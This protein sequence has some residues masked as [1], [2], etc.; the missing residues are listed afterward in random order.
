[1]RD[2]IERNPT[3]RYLQQKY[4]IAGQLQKKAAERPEKI[5]SAASVLADLGLGLL[6]SIFAVV[7]ILILA[8]FMLGRGR[9]WRDGLLRLLPADRATC[10]LRVTDNVAAA[11]G[12]YAAGRS[13]RR[14]LLASPVTS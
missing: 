12:N 10:W 2:F 8:A 14:S 6:N 3:L 13:L 4:D 1:V 11:L 7:T 9:A 5:G